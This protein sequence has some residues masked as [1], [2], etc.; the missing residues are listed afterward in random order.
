MRVTSVPDRA[1]TLIMD[2]PSPTNLPHFYDPYKGC[3]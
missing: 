3:G 2:A 1:I